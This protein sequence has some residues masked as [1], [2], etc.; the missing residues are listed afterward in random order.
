MIASLPMYA[1]PS[2]RAAHD[3]LWALIRDGLRHRGI[4]A[5]DQLDQDTD[6]M[7]GWA[8]DDLVLG[9]ICNLPYRALFKDK[10]TFIG[11]ADYEL[12]G[13]P[14]GYYRSVFVVRKDSTAT[15]PKDMA[16][17]RFALNE[18]LSQ[19]GYGA[20]QL[21]AQA[22]GFQF[23]DIPKTSSHRGSIAAVAE[24]RADIAAIDAHT[25]WIEQAENP[26]THQL[27][28]IGHTDATPGMSFITRK[29]QNPALYFD[30]IAAAI[31]ALS[32]DASAILGL[33]GI[34][35][36]PQTA[37]DLPFPPKQAAIPV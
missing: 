23:Q 8:R 17:Q 35:A 12:D 9:Q 26:Q 37:Y 7:E 36:L 22:R 5:P 14:P 33:K 27:K 29:G 31:A 24:G 4:A 32:L 19:S 1:R 6:H 13:C 16:I 15:T 2:N 28:V 10:V 30:A 18:P 21:W 20:P 3:A 34:I 11:A 25:W